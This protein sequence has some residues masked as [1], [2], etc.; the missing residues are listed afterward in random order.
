VPKPAAIPLAS[1]QAEVARVIASPELSGARS[2]ADFLR[3]VVEAAIDG[4]GAQIKEYVIG[5]EVFGRGPD[6]DPRT[7]PIVRVQALKLR[8][9]LERYYQSADRKGDVQI[10]LTKGSYVPEFQFRTAPANPLFRGVLR[11]RTAAAALAAALLLLC[12]AVF[13]WYHRDVPRPRISSLAVLPFLNL[14]GNSGNDYLSD[15]L[16]EELLDHLA[17][18]EGLRV[19]ARTSS[20]QFRNQAGDIG[21]IGR[22]LRVSAVLEGSI[23]IGG[24]RIRVT[25]QLNRVDDGYHMWS[26]SFDGDLRNALA[27]EQD[28]AQAIVRQLR[29]NGVGPLRNPPQS[30]GTQ[31][32]EAYNLYLQGRYFWNKRTEEGFRTAIRRFQEATALDPGY[33]R[34]WTGLADSYLLLFINGHTAP[35]DV[36]PQAGQAVGKALSLDP[37]LADAHAANANLMDTREDADPAA[38]EAEYRRAL[39]LN[40]AYASAHQFYSR[41]LAN[42]QRFEE[43]LHEVQI[44]EELDPV[45]PIISHARGLTLMNMG[46]DEAALAAFHRATELVPDFPLSLERIARYAARHGDCPA[47][48][49]AQQKASSSAGELRRRAVLGEILATCGNKAQAVDIL[50]DVLASTRE[51]YVSPYYVASLAM[52]VGNRKV[53]LDELERAWREEYPFVRSLSTNSTYDPLRSE[54]R[55]QA[56]LAQISD[57]R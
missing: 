28:L 37:S 47:A 6:F 13:Y 46:H 31:N 40:P 20:F 15:G 45:S 23:R 24:S 8:A 33:S 51:R 38:T 27:L 9:R 34:A 39:A 32:H 14:T 22:K 54:P 44:A 53:A 36:L 1:I 55:F 4:R 19:P 7:D 21:E 25:A 56:L 57:S 17:H 52:A 2:L 50:N 18:I 49:K 35:R 3:F 5:V 48:I 10:V 30:R 43:S 42:H 11:P 16:T 29:E 12:P 41:F 26:G